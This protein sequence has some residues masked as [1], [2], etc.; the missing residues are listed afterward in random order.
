MRELLALK[1][2]SKNLDYK[3]SMNWRTATAEQKAALVKD[4]L[5]MANTQDGGKIIFGVRDSDF[6]PIGLTDEEFES[7]DTTRFADLL[8]RYA[9]PSFACVVHKLTIDDKRYAVIEVPEFGV[10][11]IICKADANNPTAGAEAR[12]YIHSDQPS[13]FRSCPRRRSNA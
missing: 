11:P 7:F 12:S 9:D 2:E 8:N 10:V 13:G 4:A 5:A 1:S 6:E 3:Q